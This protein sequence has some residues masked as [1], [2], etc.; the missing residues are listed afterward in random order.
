MRD[1]VIVDAVRTPVGKRGGALSQ[2]HPT[3]LSARVLEALIA[4]NDLDPALVD[5]VHWGCVHQV[6]EQTYN[7]A[8]NAVIAAGWPESV[9]GTTLDRQCGSSQQ[10]VHT[11]AAAI[12]SGQQD[13][14]VAGGVEVMSL[15]PMGASLL[16]R[17]PFGETFAARYD[18]RRPHMG[19]GAETMNDRWGL[20]RTQ[21][22]E[23]ALTS[24][25]KADSAAVSGAFDAQLLTVTNASGE[26]VTRDEG[27]RPG[28]SMDKLAALKPVFKEDGLLTAGN[29][30]PINDGAAG[31][32]LMSR[33]RA[34]ELGLRPIAR[35]HTAVV[36]GDDPIVSLTAMIPA[37]AKVLTRSGLSLSDIGVFEVS[38][39]FASVPLAWLSETGADASLMNPNGGAIAIGHP[40]GASGARLMTTMVHHM[41]DKGIRYGLQTM[42]EG[43]GMSNATILEL[44]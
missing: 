20:T 41:R 42:C 25:A 11:A 26:K 12:V 37:T 17:D 5:D 6:A 1:A 21:L 8:R 27:I 32:L 24:H 19:L 36:T 4:R 43:G 28:G 34:D 38:E 33:E 3:D 14:V 22:D 13:I 29:S 23:F 16:D 35:V 31:L 2:E 9:P 10:A 18:G 7:V 39:A 30:S 15:I 44:V 40:L